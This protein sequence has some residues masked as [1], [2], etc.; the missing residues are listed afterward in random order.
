MKVIDIEGLKSYQQEE[1]MLL[2]KQ[3]LANNNINFLQKSKEDLKC[4][5]CGSV[6]Y[7]KNGLYLKKQRY[8]C[9]DCR[10]SFSAVSDTSV[11]YI[12]K[13]DIW[14]DFIHLM[15]S[16]S[17]PLTLNELSQKLHLSTKTVHVWKHK[18]LAGINEI[19]EIELNNCV[20]M[21]EI[22]V[23]FC[24]KG[25]KGKEKTLELKE[26]EKVLMNDKYNSIFM[27]FH[28]RNNDFD[29]FPLKVQKK[30]N[31]SA[32]TIKSV[33]DKLEI[34]KGTVIITDS[35]K[36]ANKYLKTRT[37]LIHN[38]F[39]SNDYST[40]NEVVHNNHINGVMSMFKKWS[41][42]FNGFSTKYV[43]NY[44]KWFRFH[45]KFVE[46]KLD[47]M[48]SH[49]VSDIKGNIRYNLINKFYEQFIY[50]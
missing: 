49:S 44:L 37:D 15:L 36:S 19:S 40:Q 17:T 9:K 25:K 18:F 50:A 34:S 3:F 30:G 22:Y 23:P 12:H 5:S 43:W 6:H 8:K 7:V 42:R 10:Y 31:V 27:C 13:T 20:E 29:F 33:V 47:I 46:T 26:T 28:N 16:Y 2:V 38:S 11:H 41:K 39:V 4:P 24:V 21:D 35:G 45:R 1:L 48:V 14:T 32:E